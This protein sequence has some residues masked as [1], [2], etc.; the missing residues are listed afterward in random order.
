MRGYIYSSQSNR[1]TV[2]K[3]RERQYPKMP[4]DLPEPVRPISFVCIRFSD[5]FE[6]NIL[7]SECIHD[8]LN[9]FIV[10]DNRLNLYYPTLA[11]AINAGI[12]QAV[13]DLIVVVHEDVLLLPEWQ[14][15]FEKSL[16]DLE[17]VDN[18]WMVL[19]VVGWN[20]QHRIVGRCSDPNRYH[21][22]GWSKS[23][24]KVTRIDE[25]L[26]VL[27]R[28]RMVYP[29]PNLPTI[30]NLGRDLLRSVKRQQGSSYIVNAPTIHKFADARGER[31]LSIVDSGKITNRVNL[32]YRQQKRCSDEYLE[33]KWSLQSS[34]TAQETDWKA[35][36]PTHK[37]TLASPIIAITTDKRL[38]RHVH[39]P[40]EDYVATSSALSPRF[41]VKGLNQ[42]S[43]VF[44]ALQNKDSFEDAEVTESV[45][46]AI[47]RKL[48][49]P[50]S[51]HLE[52][53]QNDLIFSAFQ[54]L[55]ENQWPET[56]VITGLENILVL[57]ELLQAF[58]NASV[59]IDKKA[60]TANNAETMKLSNPDSELG[61][62]MLRLAYTA[63]GQNLETAITATNEERKAVVTAYLL[64]KATR[65]QKQYRR[66]AYSAVFQTTTDNAGALQ[67]L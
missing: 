37:N 11:Q 13:H 25:Q 34:E 27:N 43:V 50:D 58:S 66:A 39:L 8:E 2:K 28:Q 38:S 60:F 23:F 56:W 54:Y 63:S 7:Q 14:S 52:Q 1:M 65:L 3:S 62:L 61:R 44:E 16:A 53:I 12:E 45:L 42:S 17:T 6:H 29:D 4:K 26:I 51:W 59:I 33:H 30:H 46:R 9:Q 20:Q 64:E 10:V 48:E 18:N 21:N 5:E 22:P 47:F 67:Q 55:N 57:E 15:T 35:L 36:S 19:G 40:E 31:V 32:I 24:R 41:N 49:C